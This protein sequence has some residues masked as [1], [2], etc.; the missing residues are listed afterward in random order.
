MCPFLSHLWMSV[1][2]YRFYSFSREDRPMRISWSVFCFIGRL[3]IRSVINLVC[4]TARLGHAWETGPTS[5]FGLRWVVYEQRIRWDWK[6]ERKEESTARPNFETREMRSDIRDMLIGY[7]SVSLK[8]NQLRNNEPVRWGQPVS[9]FYTEEA[10]II[11]VI[12]TNKR[13]VVLTGQR[14]R[15]RSCLIGRSG[16]E[17]ELRR[18]TKSATVTETKLLDEHWGECG[19]WIQLNDLIYRRSME[20]TH[21]LKVR[22]DSVHKCN[23]LW[24]SLNR[25]M[26]PRLRSLFA[27]ASVITWTLVVRGLGNVS[28]TVGLKA[29]MAVPVM[30]RSGGER[31]AISF[32]TRKRKSMPW[33]VV[34]SSVMLSGGSLHS[35]PAYTLAQKKND[36]WIAI[37]WP[38]GI[39]HLFEGIWR[40]FI[41]S[42]FGQR[43]SCQCS[44]LNADGCHQYLDKVLSALRWIGNF[45]IIEFIPLSR[46]ITS[47][48]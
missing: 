24:W 26:W 47:P 5:P 40:E 34:Y 23:P 41:W 31:L 20:R 27:F 43:N 39:V 9:A 32:P 8:W 46:L 16:T 21:V 37:E 35:Y 3:A 17:V 22:C 11:C 1:H 12:I 2:C 38:I 29:W 13:I 42:V 25:M 48:N 10:H 30:E 18:P 19:W 15:G 33:T 45:E 7:W 28:H 36:K 4:T 44:T 6:P 14:P